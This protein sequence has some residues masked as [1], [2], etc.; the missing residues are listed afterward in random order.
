MPV[1]LQKKKVFAWWTQHDE[2]FER[3]SSV[4]PALAQGAPFSGWFQLFHG[5]KWRGRRAHSF[6]RTETPKNAI[7][8]NRETIGF[9]F[10]VDFFVKPFRHDFFAKRFL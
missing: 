9:G 7:K 6:E 3:N 4:Q 2:P 10:L 8:R 1:F 5:P